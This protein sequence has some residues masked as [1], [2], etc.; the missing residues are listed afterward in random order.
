MR[1]VLIGIDPG[2]S[3]GIAVAT[4]NLAPLTVD[5]VKMPDTPKGILD[6]LD[7]LR[8]GCDSVSCVCEKVGTYRPGNSAISACKFARHCGGLEMAL[9]ALQ[10]PTIYVTPHKWMKTLGSM[11]KEKSERKRFI[12]NLMEQQYPHLKVTLATADALGIL[13][14]GIRNQQLSLS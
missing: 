7:S 8:T 11:P 10:I 6:M 14:Y 3:G 1:N 5:A 12:K 13:T 4:S 2:V 9:I